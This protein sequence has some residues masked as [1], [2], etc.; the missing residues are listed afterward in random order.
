MLLLVLNPLEAVAKRMLEKRY[1]Q[2]VLAN[3]D[4]Q[5]QH[6]R[7]VAEPFEQ[8]LLC[9]GPRSGRFAEMPA[10]YSVSLCMYSSTLLQA[11]PEL[12]H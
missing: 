3:G 9:L 5:H 11:N 8:D 6:C 1:R 10:K 4:E 7:R 2:A 12:S